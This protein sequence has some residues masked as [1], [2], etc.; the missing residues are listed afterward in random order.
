MRLREL[1]LTGLKWAFG[2]R[3]FKQI[4]QFIITI[5]LARLL[6]PSD[7]GIVGMVTVFTGFATIF[8]DMGV[9]LALVQKKHVKEE[10]LSSAFWVTVASGV[11]IS[12]VFVFL[13]PAIASFYNNQSL[14]PVIQVF[15][16]NFIFA[17]FSVVQQSVLQK[18]MS[19]KKIALSESVAVFISGVIAIIMAFYGYG[20][21]SLVFQTILFTI[22]NVVILFLLSPW[23]PKFIFSWN[24]FKEIIYFSA[25]VTGFN[26]I[27]YFSRNSDY[28][29]IGKFL[30]PVSLGYYTL[31]YKLM[32][33]P[34]QNIS[35]IFGK[36]VFPAFSKMQEDLPRL[37]VAYL[38]VIKAISL[39]TFP[40]MLFIF[41][42]SKEFIIVIYGVKWERVI[43]IITILSI[44][45]LFQSI[46]TTAGNIF[47]SQGAC[48]KQLKL[49]I[50][51]T[52]F[53]LLA[54]FIG[55]RWDIYGVALFYTLEQIIWSLIVQYLANSLIK[56]EMKVFFKELYNSVVISL[57]IVSFLLLLRLFNLNVFSFFIVASIAALCVY[58]VLLLVFNEIGYRRGR[59][60]IKII[61]V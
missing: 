2:A 50:I 59:M 49:S 10:H 13:S 27:N 51:G 8:S 39:V 60:Y 28:L 25:N 7:F 16:L 4:S 38:K 33:I 58:F 15:S 5:I 37:R 9:N 21:W 17:S 47:F 20:Y 23:S 6:S 3:L 18:S 30:G 54:I 29:L 19:F 44:C 11:L 40:L 52:I 22:L 12:I 45:G 56:L 55:I 61:D 48:A 57:I 1:T 26:V 24:S 41:G 31:A 43:P 53:V 46:S 42:I 36:V 32:M 14:K 34:L 35:S